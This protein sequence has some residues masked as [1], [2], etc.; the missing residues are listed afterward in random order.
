MNFVAIDFETA[1]QKR[2]SA[3]S[4]AV[5]KVVNNV[6]TE[7]HCWL[8]QP[9]GNIYSSQ[10]INVHGIVPQMTEHLGNIATIHNSIM[11]LLDGAVVVA[12]NAVNFDI[13]VLCA[14]LSTA[15]LPIPRIKEV[16]CTFELSGRR[17]LDECCNEYHITLDHHD[18]MSD[19]VA[20]AQLFLLL[21]GQ[22]LVKHT[23][24][25]GWG[26]S[27]RKV[28]HETLKA[29]DLATI[30]NKET[31]FFGKRVVITGVFEQYPMRETLALKLKGYGADIQTS[32]SKRTEIVVCGTGAGPAKMKKISDLNDGGCSIMVMFESDLCQ[33][34]AD[35]E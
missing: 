9:P 21:Q 18:P 23:S 28:S 20:C 25:S 16:C 11:E 2:D 31:I 29:P 35:I 26:D 32:V 34:L 15:G 19:A 12:H 5:V 6:I 17:P 7:R 10:C 1:T 4:L 27:T 14:S 33:Y 24:V 3:C 22:P 8:F 30:S 13:D